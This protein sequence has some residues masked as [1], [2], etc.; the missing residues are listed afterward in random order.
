M[1]HRIWLIGLLALLGASPPDK[2]GL[3]LRKVD[4]TEPRQTALIAF[5]GATEVLYISSLLR[6]TEKTR[7][8]EILPLP[9]EPTAELADPRV[10]DRAA[11]VYNAR[12]QKE[13]D[14][15]ARQRR[16]EQLR[17]M[18]IM[19]VIAL[20]F[21]AVAAYFISKGRK[22]AALVTLLFCLLVLVF[23]AI[24]GNLASQRSARPET[25]VEV[26]S[27]Q[28]LGPHSITIV[29]TKVPA[30]I[31]EW[32]AELFK[33]EGGDPAAFDQGWRDLLESY[34]RN[35]CP[36][37]A[38]DLIDADPASGPIAPI[39][40]T[41]ATKEP[42]FPLRISNRGRGPTDVL[43]MLLL[44]ADAPW[45]PLD[46]ERSFEIDRGLHDGF[47]MTPPELK[48]IDPVLEE[49][50]KSTSVQ[51]HAVRWQTRLEFLKSDF[52]LKRRA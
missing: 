13:M 23:F 17:A 6:P 19:A 16:R 39:R 33:K 1:R 9:G 11:E 29:K 37:F 22:F 45:S 30:D 18:G 42:W 46:E 38:V 15:R 10:I 31:S 24:P 40:Y 2:G 12:V 27:Q 49:R 4:V 41:F 52:V 44:P 35:G 20:P 21:L 51:L 36:Y 47:T 43:L 7:I 14:K 3:P 34:V 26:L 25:T 50:F 48:S 32:V 5:D 8:L 28:Q